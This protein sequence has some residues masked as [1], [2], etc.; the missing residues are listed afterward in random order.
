[1][2]SSRAIA[3]PMFVSRC[4][5][6]G[7]FGW[8]ERAIHKKSI[9][10]VYQRRSCPLQSQTTIH[11]LFVSYCKRSEYVKRVKCLVTQAME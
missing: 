4:L 5:V 2:T 10:R 8:S 9:N 6:C 11:N 1:M 3:R 7:I